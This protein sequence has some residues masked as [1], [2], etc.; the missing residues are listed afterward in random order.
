MTDLWVFGYGSLMWRPG[1]AYEEALRAQLPGFH[2][3]L[4]IWS[5]EYRGTA[6]WPGLVFGLDRGGA[7]EGMAYRIAPGR[8]HEVLRYLY[9]RELTTGVYTPSWHTI[10]LHA[11]DGGREARALAFVADRTHRQY[12]GRLPLSTQAAIVRAARGETGRNLDYVVSTA[13][14]LA[15]IGIRDR[16]VERLVSLVGPQHLR[17]GSPCTAALPPSGLR[18]PATASRPASAA[19]RIGPRLPPPKS[20]R[21]SHRRHLELA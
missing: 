3:A 15:E 19:H 18:S 1:F 16:S 20:L 14:H 17:E 6:D 8:R 4:C 12:A 2:R 9:D 5:L 7:C 13:R 21:V 10:D 11:W